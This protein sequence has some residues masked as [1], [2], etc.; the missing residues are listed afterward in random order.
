MDRVAQ[1]WTPPNHLEVRV[2]AR[3]LSDDRLALQVALER[4]LALVAA[5]A[6]ALVAAEREGRIAVL[7]G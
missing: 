6:G 3:Q 4:L 1:T 2:L 7:G 5:D